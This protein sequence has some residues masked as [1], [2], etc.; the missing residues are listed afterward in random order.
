MAEWRRIAFPSGT[1]ERMIGFSLPR[2]REVVQICYDGIVRLDLT[3]PVTP[4]LDGTHPEGG[5]LYD[6][7]AQRLHYAGA[8]YVILGLHGG[9]PLAVSPQGERLVLTPPA[10]SG[11]SGRQLLVHGPTATTDLRF[12]FEERSG[13]W[14]YA[15]FS[16]DGG[17]VVAGAPYDLFAFE[18][19][20]DTASAWV[21]FPRPDRQR[22]GAGAT[23][24]ASPAGHDAS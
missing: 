16:A 1:C 6:A 20:P 3:G 10:A 8:T 21:S 15:T 14:G 23:D 22:S 7:R 4:T 9:A 11:P 13:D 19:V 17:L 5:E 2:G 12:E 24:R 18:R